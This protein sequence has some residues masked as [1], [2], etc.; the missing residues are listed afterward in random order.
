[1]LAI[2]CRAQHA[3]PGALCAECRA[4]LAYA[5]EKLAKCPFGAAKPTCANCPVH[6]YQPA[7]RAAIRAVMACAGPRMLLRHPLMTLQHT[8]AGLRRPARGKV[9]G[10]SKAGFTTKGTKPTKNPG[11]HGLAAESAPASGS[12]PGAGL[13]P[14]P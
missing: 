11:L 12:S 10:R 5:R 9:E 1:M 14:T 13:K 3:G 8:L 4:L 2:Y 6:C 7:Q